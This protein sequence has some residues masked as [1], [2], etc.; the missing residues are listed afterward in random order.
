VARGHSAWWCVIN[1]RKLTGWFVEDFIEA[2]RNGIENSLYLR[3]KEASY[4]QNRVVFETVMN[5]VR[6]RSQGA[7]HPFLRTLPALQIV[8][9]VSVVIKPFLMYSRDTRQAIDAIG[10]FTKPQGDLSEKLFMLCEFSLML[11][12]LLLMLRELLLGSLFVL[13]VGVQQH[14]DR[15]GQ[16]FVTLHQ[17]VEAFVD[18]HDSIVSGPK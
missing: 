11:R 4:P 13:A 15:F 8:Q 2:L 1:D 9:S 12:E 10:N 3:T 14:L 17:P 5:R 7:S 18:G 16:S 6:A